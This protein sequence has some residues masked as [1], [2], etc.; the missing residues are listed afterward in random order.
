MRRTKGFTLIELLVVVAIIALL[1]SI[2]LPS[3]ARARELAKRAVCA[4]NLKG[5][6]NAMNIYANENSDR[7]PVIPHQIDAEVVWAGST[8]GELGAAALS[9]D[10]P[11]PPQNT[12]D[13][14]TIQDL[15]YPVEANPNNVSTTACMWLLVREGGVAPTQFYCPSSVDEKDQTETV[16]CYWDFTGYNTVSYGC[17]VAFKQGA[18]GNPVR[19]K[20]DMDSR[21]AIAADKGPM[22]EPSPNQLW[23]RTLASDQPG[24]KD[25][26]SNQ[27]GACADATGPGEGGSS[28]VANDPKRWPD[29]DDPRAAW[30]GWNSPN[31]GGRGEGE[32]QNV[33]YP[34][35]HTEWQDTPSAG[36]DG[37]NIY[38]V[39]HTLYAEGAGAPPSGN[40]LPGGVTA[41]ADRKR[42]KVDSVIYP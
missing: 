39:G 18:G 16:T 7:F 35:A 27:D 40:L 25:D 2:L 36:V 14:D 12:S 3:L 11:C 34:D 10:A 22:S 37:D 20:S 29:T 38:T 15:N 13:E 1:I 4:A 32:G 5:M 8:V 23:G 24:A 28:D 6:G 26:A 31:H 41:A 21:I 17:Q 9:G 33:L 30:A 19:F 42:A